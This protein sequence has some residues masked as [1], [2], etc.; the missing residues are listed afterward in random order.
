MAR[1]TAWWW[2]EPDGA[3]FP[4]HLNL[5]GFRGPDWR[6]KPGSRERVFFVGDS[7]VEGFGAPDGATI[8]RGFAERARRE[9]VEVEAINLGAGGFQLANYG[10]LLADAVPWF[11]PRHVLLVLY[12]NDLY[13]VPVAE[14]VIRPSSR[15]RAP[16][17]W[18]PRLLQL[19]EWTRAGREV[20]RR[21]RAPAGSEPRPLGVEPRFRAD[22]Q[23]LQSIDRFVDDDLAAAMRAGRLNPAVTNLLARSQVVLRRPVA[24]RLFLEGL[25]RFVSDHDARLWI[26]YLPSLNQASD[27]YRQA[28]ERLSRPVGPESLTT[29][30]FQVHARAIGEACA[31]L[32]IPFLDLTP[33]LQQAERGGRRLYWPYDAH[34]NS[35]GYRLAAEEIFEWWWSVQSRE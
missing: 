3:F 35:E 19:L 33:A 24:P 4:H 7:F 21:W 2:S 6:R 29:A 31:L 1:A 27:A 5:Y 11:Q 32:T 22:P 14:E 10:R 9:N 25:N 23:L 13:G 16:S 34:M 12:A 30:E 15:L 18:R 17:S 28:Q 8:P 26:V 20:P